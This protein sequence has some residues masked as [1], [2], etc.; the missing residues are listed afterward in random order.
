MGCAKAIFIFELSKFIWN[1]YD[2]H[3][4]QS[5]RPFFISSHMTNSSWFSFGQT[6]ANQQVFEWNGK[7]SRFYYFWRF[8]NFKQ[9]EI[10]CAWCWKKPIIFSF[11]QSIATIESF[12]EWNVYCIKNQALTGTGFRIINSIFFFVATISHFSQFETGKKILRFWENVEFMTDFANFELWSIKIRLLLHGFSIVV[13]LILVFMIKLW[14]LVWF[15][16]ATRF[17]IAAE[18]FIL[19]LFLSAFINICW[20]SLLEWQHQN[21]WSECVLETTIGVF[22]RIKLTSQGNRNTFQ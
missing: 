11:H 16:L 6:Q 9:V 13:F 18:N 10:V 12:R 17:R 21:P 5:I 8:W 7:N 15:F 22:Y 20:H 14:F 2:W 19:S 3:L 1:Y 4:L